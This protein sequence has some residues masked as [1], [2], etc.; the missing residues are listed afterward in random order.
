MAR[1]SRLSG[2]PTSA[3]YGTAMTA[4]CLLADE[5]AKLCAVIGQ[6]SEYGTALRVACC[7]AALHQA[8]GRIF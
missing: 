8:I 4:P 6:I 3:S 1:R 2:W 7:S 5:E